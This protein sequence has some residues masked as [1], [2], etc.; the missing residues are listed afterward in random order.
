VDTTSH[1]TTADHRLPDGLEYTL[2]SYLP[3]AAEEVIAFL[4]KHMTRDALIGSGKRT[5]V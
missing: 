2:T 5:D 1:C 3:G 4:Q